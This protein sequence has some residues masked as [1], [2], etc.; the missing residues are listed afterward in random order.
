MAGEMQEI[1]I[2]KSPDGFEVY[3]YDDDGNIIE[4]FCVE[5]ITMEI[6]K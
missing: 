6:S 5:K 3:V 2:E 4:H 1:R